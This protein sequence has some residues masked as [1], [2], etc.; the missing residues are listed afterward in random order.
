VSQAGTLLAGWCLS[1][2]TSKRSSG[3]RTRAVDGSIVQNGKFSAATFCEQSTLNVVDFPTLGRPTSP[4][5]TELPGRPSIGGSSTGPFFGG[6]VH[7]GRR[8]ERSQ[9]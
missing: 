1:Q 9:N 2:S 5:E 3:T 8:V 4:A 7:N 6:M